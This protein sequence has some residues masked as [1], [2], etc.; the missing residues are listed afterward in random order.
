[1]TGPTCGFSVKAAVEVNL[2]EP[3]GINDHV[4]QVAVLPLPQPHLNQPPF[5]IL[6]VNPCCGSKILNYGCGS[7]RP[8]NLRIMP[9]PDSPGHFWANAKNKKYVVK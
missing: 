6:P 3:D 4:T 1:M 7:G 5:N 2:G 8:I 9:D